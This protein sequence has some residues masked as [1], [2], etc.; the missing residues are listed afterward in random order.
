MLYAKRGRYPLELTM[1]TR[2]IGFWNRLILD[3]DAKISRRLYFILRSIDDPGFK[4]ISHVQSLL[5]RVGRNDLWMLQDNINNTSLNLL[6]KRT[7]FD[8]FLQNWR[9]NLN[10]SAKG[11]NYN[12]FKIYNLCGSL[13]SWH[14]RQ[15]PQTPKE[16]K[17][18]ICSSNPIM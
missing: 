4:L 17:W 15:S 14:A 13:S 1:K 3:K 18:R 8:Q 16:L 5:R 7:L 2:T 11:R 9:S 12:V 10:N 6:I